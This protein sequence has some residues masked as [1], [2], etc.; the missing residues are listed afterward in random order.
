[1]DYKMV[2]TYGV[3]SEEIE[4]LKKCDN[5]GAARGAYSKELF[6]NYEQQNHVLKAIS[7]SEADK[8]NP[9]R[10]NTPVLIEGKMPMSG[11]C[12]IEKKITAPHS[13]KIGQPLISP[14]PMRINPSPTALNTA[15]IR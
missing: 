13:F 2:S 6:Y 14:I 5:V 12:L 7:Y 11:E 1:M 4:K 15:A 3:S 8:D 9:N 10:L